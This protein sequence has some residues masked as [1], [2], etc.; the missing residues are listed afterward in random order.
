MSKKRQRRA[1]VNLENNFFI[2]AKFTVTV[3]VSN[4]YRRISGKMGFTITLRMIDWKMF[5]RQQ[6]FTIFLISFIQ[7]HIL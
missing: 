1:A 7:I 6:N 2:L 5:L 4:N 3:I